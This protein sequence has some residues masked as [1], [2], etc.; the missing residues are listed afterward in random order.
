MANKVLE[1][2]VSAYVEASQRQDPRVSVL[3]APAE[4][5]PHT[6]LAVC[7][8]GDTLH[9]DSDKLIQRL[10]DNGHQ[11]A[12]LITVE[13]KAHAFDKAHDEESVALAK[14]LYEQCAEAIERAWERKKASS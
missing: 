12:E 10:K 8:T 13:G 7:G 5:Y 9:E 14:K 2:I 11:D 1:S 4:R 6:V 3:L